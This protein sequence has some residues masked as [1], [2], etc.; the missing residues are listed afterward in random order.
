MLLRWE[1]LTIET[2]ASAN[3]PQEP[4]THPCATCDAFVYVQ[5]A[6]HEQACLVKDS[7]LHSERLMCSSCYPAKKVHTALDPNPFGFMGYFSRKRN[8]C[9]SSV[10]Y[11]TLSLGSNLNHYLYRSLF[12]DLE[13]E[14]ASLPNHLL[15]IDIVLSVGAHQVESNRMKQAIKYLETTSSH[16]MHADVVVVL[17]IK[18]DP[19]LGAL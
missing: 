9:A 8:K 16:G 10:L 19:I 11:I 5:T 13:V 18:A 2:D 17:N 15:S 1:W 14:Y 7:I 4:R 3:I 6:D 12:L